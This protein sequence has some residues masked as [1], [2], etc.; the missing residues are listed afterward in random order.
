MGAKEPR[1]RSCLPQDKIAMLA[2]LRNARAIVYRD[3]E[4]FTESA[5]V[6]EHVGQ[7]LRGV[8]GN[9][10]GA[11]KNKICDL[12]HE[13]P[14]I[15]SERVDVLFD[16]VRRARN[17][18]VHSGDYIRHHAARLVELLLVLEEGLSMFA[19]VAG[20][21]MVRNPT[22]AESWHTIAAIRRAML[23]NS[24]SYLPAQDADDVWKLLSDFSIVK[25]LNGV[26]T[27]ERNAM[28]GKQLHKVLE[29]R[30]ITL[31]ECSRISQDTSIEDISKDMTNVP[32]LVVETDGNKERLIGILSAFD[33]I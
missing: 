4:S 5:A 31:T 17:D 18:S 10:L 22:T 20:D 13:A 7:M 12:A 23:T 16:T 30:D 21:L 26:K 32:F 15:Q 1:Q 9:G 2:M 27:K 29:D 28:L 24:F 19:K 3:A 14:S 6:L 33:L 11:Y 8:V 25:Y